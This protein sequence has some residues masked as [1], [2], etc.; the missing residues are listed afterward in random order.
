MCD[1]VRPGMP[2]AFSQ[3]FLVHAGLHWLPVENRER[4][5]MRE[6]VGAQVRKGDFWEEK[7]GWARRRET[8]PGSSSLHPLLS[9]T[10]LFPTLQPSLSPSGRMYIVTS[11]RF[12]SFKIQLQANINWKTVQ[13]PR[14]NSPN[15][16]VHVTIISN[17][18]CKSCRRVCELIFFIRT[19]ILRILRNQL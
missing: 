7:E 17:H 18:L 5:L 16:F 12:K 2:P 15:V 3:R 1:L 6:L 8:P 19:R 4:K 13:F 10:L 11:F 9:N 14:N